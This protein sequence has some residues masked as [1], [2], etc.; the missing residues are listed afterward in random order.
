MTFFRSL[1]SSSIVTDLRRLLNS[2]SL[3][4]PRL[5]TSLTKLPRRKLKRTERPMLLLT[6]IR[7]SSRPLTKRL[8]FRMRF[9]K[10]T[11]LRASLTPSSPQ[12]DLKILSARFL[13]RTSSTSASKSTVSS[14]ALLQRPARLPMLK[15]SAYS[16]Q[17][18]RMARTMSPALL[19][20]AQILSSRLSLRLSSAE[21]RLK[22]SSSLLLR[23]LTLQKA[24][25]LRQF[26]TP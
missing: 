15:Q 20:T 8:W 10:L 24:Q 26:L 5:L 1:C 21:R 25:P 22:Q 12:A 3:R 13:L 11:T 6:S 19:Q 17:R 4:S 9:R 14:R 2:S 18:K 16:P 23:I 7:C